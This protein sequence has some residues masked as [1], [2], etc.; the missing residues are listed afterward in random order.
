MNSKENYKNKLNQMVKEMALTPKMTTRKI[1][2]M[3]E[4]E[5]KIKKI[6][7]MLKIKMINQS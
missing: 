1:R 3:M 6:I 7:K 2:K 4:K 5:A